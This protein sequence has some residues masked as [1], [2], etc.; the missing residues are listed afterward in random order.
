M[1]AFP[2]DAVASEGFPVALDEPA[3]VAAVAAAHG[4][5][6]VPDDPFGGLLDAFDDERVGWCYGYQVPGLD[7][8]LDF[9]GRVDLL[10]SS[11]HF[12]ILL[13]YLFLGLSG[14]VASVYVDLACVGDVVV[15]D[16]AVDPVDAEPALHDAVGAG[17]AVLPG[18]YLV[19]VSLE[20]GYEAC[21]VGDG[22]YALL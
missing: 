13:V 2:A 9:Q 17:E 19:G 4:F 3:V 6:G 15:G 22:V 18:V 12:L 16:A 21:G 7:P 10:C 14:G 1:E 20:L 5:G 11:D 8:V